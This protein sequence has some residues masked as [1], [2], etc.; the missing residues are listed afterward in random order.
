[1]YAIKV[2]NIIFNNKTYNKFLQ[3][4]RS[5]SHEKYYKLI[6]I[7]YKL[8][9]K[10]NLKNIYQNL[11]KSRDILSVLSFTKKLIYKLL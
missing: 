4:V 3:E 8:I 2:I 11:R 6:T 9:L 7:D 10:Y 5:Y 1:M